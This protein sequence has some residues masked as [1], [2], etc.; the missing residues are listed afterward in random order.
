VA[1]IVVR[2]QY[3]DVPDAQ[4]LA[5]AGLGAESMLQLSEMWQQMKQREFDSRFQQQPAPA[6]SPRPAPARVSARGSIDQ[7][8]Q[9]R[10][11]RR[12]AIAEMA[13]QRGQSSW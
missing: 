10:Q 12:S 6:P 9:A 3:V 2:N 5:Y 11:E 7:E 1:R 8:S 13:K 4:A